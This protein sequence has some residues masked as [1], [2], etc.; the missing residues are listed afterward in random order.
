MGL[1]RDLLNG[2]LKKREF[3]LVESIGDLKDKLAAGTKLT[4]EEKTAINNYERYKANILNAEMDEAR[5]QNKFKQMQ[6][7]ANLGDWREFLKE[8]YF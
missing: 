5:F 4:Y 3:T 2:I 6:V 8:E 1:G 7:I